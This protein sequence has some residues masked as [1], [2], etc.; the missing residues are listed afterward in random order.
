MKLN[1]RAPLAAA[2]LLAG[3]LPASAQV[4]F[5]GLLGTNPAA[6]GWT[7]GGI[8]VFSETQ[9]ANAVVFDTTPFNATMAGYSWNQSL[10]NRNTG[11]VVRFD[12]QLLQESH[13]RVDRAG[14]SVIA[15][16]QDKKGI[17]LGFWGNRIWAQEQGFTQA[18]GVAFDTLS[19]LTAYTLELQ[20]N[21]YRL[22]VGGQPILT[23]ALRDYS[24]FGAPYTVPNFLFLGDD[25]S[26]G[27]GRFRLRQVAVNA[28]EPAAGVLALLGIGALAV[29]RRRRG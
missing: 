18:E 3:A 17:E 16:T 9:E 7:S 8:G 26:S 21:A 22:R 6:Q 24:G 1:A 12:V 20:G 19:S 11:A 29:T 25:T 2:C 10:L 27:Q 14:F 5:D 13:I 15:L 4:I 28:P 23:G